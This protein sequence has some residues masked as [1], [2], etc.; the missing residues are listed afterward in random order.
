[1][2]SN[3]DGLRLL[4]LHLV[5][6]SL[7]PHFILI[8]VPA[9]HDVRLLGVV[10]IRGAVVEMPFEQGFGPLG[11]MYWVCEMIALLPVEIIM[12]NR[13]HLFSFCQNTEL[14]HFPTSDFS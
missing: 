8:S 13:R 11:N 4:A 10:F 5:P 3:V 9:T 2:S 14:L 7:I 6:D 12:W 1:M